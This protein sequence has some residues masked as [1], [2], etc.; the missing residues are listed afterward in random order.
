MARQWWWHY[1]ERLQ[2]KR[3]ACAYHG[4]MMAMAKIDSGAKLDD[5]LG[6]FEL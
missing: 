3:H 5:G 4:E 6:D 2:R 1:Y